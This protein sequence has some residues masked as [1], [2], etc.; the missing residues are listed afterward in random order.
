MKPIHDGI[1]WFFA[2]ALP[3]YPVW[4]FLLMPVFF[5][6]TGGMLG[7]TIAKDRMQREAVKAGVGDWQPD[8]HGRLQFKWRTK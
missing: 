5:L 2:L 7:G 6:V 1:D 4:L 3:R 8:Q